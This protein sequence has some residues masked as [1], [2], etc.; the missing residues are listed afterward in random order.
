MAGLSRR[1]AACGW[2]ELREVGKGLRCDI[3]S[4]QSCQSL[5]YDVDWDQ[6]P[7]ATMDV[8]QIAERRGLEDAEKMFSNIMGHTWASCW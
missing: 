5:N 1:I 2:R 7:D 8:M 3:R 4:V 6:Y